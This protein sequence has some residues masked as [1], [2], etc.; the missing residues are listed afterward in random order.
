MNEKIGLLEEVF[1]KISVER[2]LE[3]V[4]LKISVE[5]FWRVVFGEIWNMNS[6]F[7]TEISL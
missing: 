1:L 6:C 3:E 4:F 2:F 5:G 7:M